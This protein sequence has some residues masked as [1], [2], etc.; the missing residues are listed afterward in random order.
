M[1][2]RKYLL[3]PKLMWHGLRARA[4]DATA[5]E[6]YWGGIQR[7]GAEGEVL[8]DAGSQSEITRSLE[9]LLPRMDSSLPIVD[10]GCGN[11]RHTRVLAAHFPKAHGIDLSSQAIEKARQESRGVANVS[12]DVSDLSVPGAGKRLA[13]ELGD[14]NVYVRGVLHIVEHRRRLAMVRNLR[15]MLGARGTLYLL[16]TAHEGSPLDY[17]TSLGATPSWIPGP[18]RRLIEAG[19]RAPQSFGELRFRRYFPEAEWEPLASGSA[20]LHG[21][22]MRTQSELE[23]IPA[24]FAIVRRRGAT[25]AQA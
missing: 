19:I 18:M 25:S 9:R 11:G 24:F 12:F 20:V 16:E 13:A 7:T 10:V 5:W 4:D 21:V 17:M 2:W 23:Q 6:R 3:V 8:W 1:S 22:P 14:M 15:D